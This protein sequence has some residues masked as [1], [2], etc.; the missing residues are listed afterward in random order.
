[1]KLTPLE[2]RKQEFRKTLRGFDPLEVQT[3]L[4]MV[5]EQYEKLMEENKELHRQIIELRTKLQDYQETE[6]TLR[7]TLVNVQ[8]VK[9][10]SEENSRRQADLI[11]KEAELKAIEILENARKQARQIR[12]EV[13]WLRSQKESFINR[14]RHILIAQIELLSV[15]EIDEA[16]PEEVQQFMKNQKNRRLN[17]LKSAQGVQS[18]EADKALPET[19]EAILLDEGGEGAESRNRPGGDK[20]VGKKEKS[21]GKYSDEEI[22]DFIKKGIDI[23]ELIKDINK[24]DREK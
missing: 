13:N 15:M 1:M 3:F 11:I 7:E 21:P 2:I 16:V 20:E 6:K 19:D 5:A 18:T 23:D 14:L 9:K 8:E 24:K 22:N 4:E 12:E 10:Q 17:A